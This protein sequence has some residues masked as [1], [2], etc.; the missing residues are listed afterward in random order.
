MIP[1]ERIIAERTIEDIITDS[2]Y[3]IKWFGVTVYKRSFH[4]D[5][6]G[7]AKNTCGFNTLPDMR[8]EIDDD[9]N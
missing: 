3:I 7:I 8:Q 9:E 2:V 5:V 4:N 1:V 6:V